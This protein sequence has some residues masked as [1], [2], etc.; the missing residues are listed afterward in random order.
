M[1][2]L[3]GATWALSKRYPLT[4]GL[5]GVIEGSLPIGGLSSSAAVILAFLSLVLV[6]VMII[7]FRRNRDAEIYNVSLRP[8]VEPAPFTDMPQE[9]PVQVQ[10]QTERELPGMENPYVK[11]DK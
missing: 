10:A 8:A 9:L 4:E 6:F 2:H 11:N 1:L 5:S 7:F 3:R